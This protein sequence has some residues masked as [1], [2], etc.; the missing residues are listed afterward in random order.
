MAGIAVPADMAVTIKEE[1]MVVR[2]GIA[3]VAV[4]SRL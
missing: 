3:V 4:M 2:A 1:G